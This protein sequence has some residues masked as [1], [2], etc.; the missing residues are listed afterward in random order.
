MAFYWKKKV[1]LA[2]IETVYGTDPTPTGSN[3][4][5]G[6]NISLNPME[7]EDVSRNLERPYFGG[8]EQLPTAVHAVLT[9]DVEMVGS[10]EL[11]VPPG[12]GIL[13]RGCACAE[14]V[15]ADTSVEY[16]PIS[17]TLESLTFYL[18]ID[19]N[20]HELNGSRG[21]FVGT[22][23]A[24]GIP[25]WRYTFTGLFV[26]PVA[27][28]A[29]TPD[30]TIWQAPQVATKANTPTFSIDGTAFRLRSFEFNR[31][32]QVERRFLIG[33]EAIEIVDAVESLTCQ[34][35]AVA[36]ATYNPFTAP[37][38]DPSPILLTHG[39]VAETRVKL[40]FPLSKQ[41]RPS[42]ANEQNIL[43]WPLTF[44][45]LPSDAGNDQWAIELS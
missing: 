27:A 34:V 21:T 15:T 28:A 35:E 36:L 11:G 33:Y 26:Q 17:S 16:A 30:Y 37:T 6:T 4:I 40:S 18:N 1:L 29:A 31:G 44:D 45:P 3:A 10:G 39:T 2:K 20:L 41:R 42:Y 8:Q 7:G 38:G 24:Q 25:V 5:L 12:W 14:I 43:E 9:F 22:I 32:A 13:H 23:N 19:G